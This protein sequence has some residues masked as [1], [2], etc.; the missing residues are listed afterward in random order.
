[1]CTSFSKTSFHSSLIFVLSGLILSITCGGTKLFAQSPPPYNYDTPLGTRIHAW[2]QAEFNNQIL[3]FS[4]A[5]AVPS[6]NDGLMLRFSANMNLTRASDLLTFT[7]DNFS[8]K[9]LKVSYDSHTLKLRRFIT[10]T[11]FY[12]YVLFDPLFET[13]SS[14]EEGTW[15][16]RLYFTAS[17]LWVQ[18]ELHGTTNKRY[19]SP[20]YWGMDFTGKTHM[21]HFLN[22]ESR[23]KVKIG[24]LGNPDGFSIPTQVEL[25]A[26]TY[27]TLQTNIQQNF[28]NHLNSS[29]ASRP[30][31]TI[32]NAVS[33]SEDQLTENKL[34]VYPNPS[35]NGVFK[36][37]WIS[38]NAFQNDIQVFDISGQLIF[39]KHVQFEK[40]INQFEIDM[41]SFPRGV[42]LLKFEHAG[43]EEQSRRI[44]IE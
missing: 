5:S 43:G 9:V 10:A 13:N 41:R 16:I 19:L 28:S 1:M 37:D 33:V 3:S 32:E 40:G 6:G 29:T 42:Y 11:K 36:V 2:H 25:Y 4:D 12:D 20:V 18:A 8:S 23:S 35:E 30:V 39:G 15:E 14:P 24:T 17:F 44:I 34:E 38:K 26:F 22:R 27:N 7:T 21:T 31:G